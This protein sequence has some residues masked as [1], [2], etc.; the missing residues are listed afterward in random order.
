MRA[1]LRRFPAVVI[2]SVLLLVA[3]AGPESQPTVTPTV[4]QTIQDPTPKAQTTSEP[5]SAD[6]INLPMA[7]ELIGITG[8]IN[9][10][11]FTLKS[12]RG[13]VVLIDFWTYTCVNCIRTFPFLREWHDKYAE[14]GLVI[15]GVHSP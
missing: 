8:W 10:E 14:H 7:S 3:C 9:T 12:L 11:P 13:K 4:E 1:M 2:G 5:A 15:I 6:E